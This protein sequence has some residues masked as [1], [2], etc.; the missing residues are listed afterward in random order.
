MKAHEVIQIKADIMLHQRNECGCVRRS[1]CDIMLME[2]RQKMQRAYYDK[3][4]VKY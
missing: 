3:A 2:L 1:D 4:P